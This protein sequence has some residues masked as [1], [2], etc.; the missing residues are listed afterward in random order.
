[1]GD[2]HFLVCCDRDNDLGGH[3][4]LLRHRLPHHLVLGRLVCLRLPGLCHVPSLPR[5]RLWLPHIPCRW[6]G[7]RGHLFLRALER[8]IPFQLFDDG[9]LS[10]GGHLHLPEGP[11]G[12]TS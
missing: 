6:H 12:G 11:A 8:S 2:R 3:R 9:R 5:L 4:R 7:L 10:A 1:V